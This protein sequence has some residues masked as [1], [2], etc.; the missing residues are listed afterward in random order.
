SPYRFTTSSQR[1]VVFATQPQAVEKD[2]QLSGDGHH[3]TLLGVL[4]S[5]SSD[6]VSEAAEVGVGP[7]G[8]EDVL[9]PA[10]QEAAQGAV[11]RLGDPELGRRLARVR[12]P[13]RE[14]QVRSHAPT[15][16]EATG[17]AQGED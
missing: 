9:R 14:P 16:T 12:P 10:H 4:G 13:G 1:S 2:R 17:I 11:A 15:V 7:E 6:G 8:P 5:P 3:R